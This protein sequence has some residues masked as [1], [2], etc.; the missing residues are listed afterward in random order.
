MEPVQAAQPE[1]SVDEKEQIVSNL[2]ALDE[3]D[4]NMRTEPIL[5]QFASI[6][7]PSLNQ[8]VNV[9]SIIEQAQQ[10]QQQQQQLVHSVSIMRKRVKVA[11][12]SFQLYD[13][14]SGLGYYSM[15]GV[16]SMAAS[17]CSMYK[18]CDKLDSSTAQ[19][20]INRCAHDRIFSF[21]RLECV[22]IE[23]YLC[24]PLVNKFV[25]LFY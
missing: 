21:I 20:S 16:G 15:N 24:E 2:L 14:P 10:R 11:S 19:L 18:V 3:E 1:L 5:P 6:F 9:I 22:P 17:N 7:K 4:S 8:P 13:C 23:K 12:K 25:P